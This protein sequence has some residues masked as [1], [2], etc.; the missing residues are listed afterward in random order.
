MSAETYYK[1]INGVLATIHETQRAA[2][3]VLQDASSKAADML[4]AACQ[5]ADAVTPP[6]RLAAAANRLNVMLEVVKSVRAALQV[7]T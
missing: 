1:Q 7:W 3:Q 4:K 2:L 5:P 6:A